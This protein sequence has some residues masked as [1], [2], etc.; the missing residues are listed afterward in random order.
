M[1]GGCGFR[2]GKTRKNTVRRVHRIYISLD[3]PAVIQEAVYIPPASESVVG[4]QAGRR[5]RRAW[6]MVPSSSQ[7]SSPPTG[8]PRAREVI[9]TP[10]PASRSAM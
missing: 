4:G 9:S 5:C 3:R 7:S 2:P 6:M 1:A 8:T 10:E